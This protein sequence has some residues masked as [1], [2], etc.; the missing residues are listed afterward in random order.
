MPGVRCAF[1][2]VSM[3]YSAFPFVIWDLI[4]LDYLLASVKQWWLWCQDEVKGKQM[5]GIFQL[6]QQLARHEDHIDGVD[7]LGHMQTH[8]NGVVKARMIFVFVRL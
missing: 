2:N 6:Q 4:L 3:E 1:G 8:N 7:N 5:R